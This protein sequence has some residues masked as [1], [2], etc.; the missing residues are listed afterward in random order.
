MSEANLEPGPRLGAWTQWTLRGLLEL[1]GSSTPRGLESHVA[2]LLEGTLSSG[3]IARALKNNYFRWASFELRKAGLLGGAYG[4]WELTPAGRALAEQHRGE[5]IDTPT[6]F[7]PLPADQANY[8]GPT[9]SVAVTSYDGYQLPV[10]RALEAGPMRKQELSAAVE[11]S[12][13]SLLLAGDRRI[14]PGGYRVSAYRT[15]WALT[16]MKK[17]GLILNDGKAVWAIT[18]TG[19]ARL[20]QDGPTWSISP[21]Q[22]SKA[23]VR[24]VEGSEQ[25]L[26]PPLT[27]AWP[28]TAWRDLEGKLPD[29]VLASIERRI[30]PRLGATPVLQRGSLPRNIVLYGPPGTGKTHIASL[31][32][33]ALTEEKERTPEGAWRLVQFHPSYSYEDFVQGMRPD[34]KQQQLRYEMR[35]GPFLT[36]CEAASEDPDNFYVLVVDEI[37]R[38][39][40]ARIFGELLYALEYR[41]QAVDLALGGQLIV[42]PNVVVIGTMNSVDRSV[43]LVDYALRRRFAFVRLDPDPEVIRRVRGDGPGAIRAALALT[44]LNAWLTARL[45][46][47]HA[48][49]HSFFLSAAVALEEHDAIEGV[50]REDLLPLLEEYFVGDVDGLQEARKEWS[51]ILAAL[52]SA[53]VE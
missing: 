38:G 25:P 12:V 15:S 42:P 3:Q 18:E 11:E 45:D 32:A 14:M 37:N 1:G 52:P 50:W 46:R 16:Q 34:L 35:K 17:D 51:R 7:E 9:E 30:R 41:D 48:V 23:A 33:A 21:F 28:T 53:P 5:D 8:D 31:V 39:D 40:P 24:V 43:A 2:K 27:P 20:A 6:E 22:T 26:Q 36:L 29:T 44:K 4:V 10:L 49:G 19:R 47:E 13:D